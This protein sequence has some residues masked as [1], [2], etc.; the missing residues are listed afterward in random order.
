MLGHAFP[1]SL[2][3]AAALLVG[4][5]NAA[6]RPAPENTGATVTNGSTVATITTPSENVM[7]TDNATPS[8]GETSPLTLNLGAR[9]KLPDGSQLAY[10]ELVNDSRC[11]P[12]VQC[13][14]AGNAEIR[15]RWT[16]TRGS[17]REFSLNTMPV[18]GKATSATLGE[19]EVHLHALERG[20]APAATLEIK[21]V[22]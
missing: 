20:I 5:S 1:N 9:A 3:L 14:W 18:G 10:L 22:H 16:P 13:I 8:A 15:M 17:S 7:A 6:P 12:D 21:P 4:C 11:P 2:A 19:F